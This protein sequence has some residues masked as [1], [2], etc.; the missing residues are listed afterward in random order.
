[1]K[2]FQILT[3]IFTNMIAVHAF[4]QA[5]GPIEV[6]AATYQGTLQSLRDLAPS[7]DGVSPAQSY[8]ALM[9]SRDR[10]AASLGR[11]AHDDATA[12][13]AFAP[14]YGSGVDGL[15][16][17]FQG[18]TTVDG[19]PPNPVGAV[20]ATQY[21]QLATLRIVV[22]DKATK[23]AITGS[24]SA[25]SLWTGFA[26]PC[27]T[28]NDGDAIVLYDKAADRW[29]ISQFAINSVPYYEC[30]AVSK[31]NDATGA[32]NLYAF[33]YNSLPDSPKMGVWPDAYYT[34]FNMY[35]SSFSFSGA[36]VCAY[37]RNAMLAGTSATQ[38]CFQLSS[39][40]FG[41]LP[42]DLD[43]A[44]PPPSGSPNY[45]LTFGTNSLNLWKFH[46]DWTTPA[47]TTLSSPIN[48]AVTAFT[49]ACPTNGLCIPQL[50]P[51]QK[52]DSKGDRLMFRLAYRNFGAYESL[53]V[54]HSVQVGATADA[55]AGVRWYEIRS[56]GTTPVVYQQSTYAPD[57][58]FRW[59]GSV[60]MDHQG[61]I[62]MGYNVSSSAMNPAIRYTGRLASDALNTMQTEA[63]LIEGA[64]TQDGSSR[65]GDYSAMTIDPTDDCTFWYTSEYLKSNGLK[66]STHID[67]F[68]FASCDSIGP[69]AQLA[70]TVEP[71]GN[72]GVGTTFTV[73]VSVEDIGGNV[74]TSDNATQVSLS[75]NA[76]GT[77]A[78]GTTTVSAGVAQ[79]TNLRFYTV[80]G[81]NTLQLHAVSNPL[82]N[83][84]DSNAFIVQSNAD[85]VFWNGFDLCTP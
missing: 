56:P 22:F 43:G 65:W 9:P 2:R 25:N 85:S 4:A 62:A 5:H 81:P 52:L 71:A 1:M 26:G 84:P 11:V 73:S 27:G 23:A 19:I 33:P 7:T 8:P 45:L 63:S 68:K 72:Y 44:N 14:I 18:A 80:T 40:V 47:N 21:V 32:Y 20:G 6:S 28:D 46:V 13:S 57:G 42:A 54:N 29:I 48:I 34:T 55:S 10:R 82:L 76:C 53:V 51:T 74:V 35:D 66:W 3:A 16:F 39:T 67:S 36:R 78:L 60:A 59:M 75:V 30:V 38:Q 24:K 41:V 77:T 69:P 12:Y 15:G 79:F 64:G 58:S 49:P 50:G 37:D 70:F 31:T 61:N 17:G 83:S